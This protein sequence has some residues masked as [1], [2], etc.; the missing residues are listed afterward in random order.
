MN[1]SSEKIHRHAIDERSKIGGAGV[2]PVSRRPARHLTAIIA[3]IQRY[4]TA[5]TMTMDVPGFSHAVVSGQSFIKGKLYMIM[6]S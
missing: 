3:T 2:P 6:I 4:I 5:Q 1:Q